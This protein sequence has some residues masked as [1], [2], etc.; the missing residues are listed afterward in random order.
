[1]AW[2][3]CLDFPVIHNATEPGIDNYEKI[4]R[5]YLITFLCVIGLLGNTMS[6][7]VLRRDPLRREALLMLQA[8]AVADGCY[9][10]VALLRYPFQF[11]LHSKE[12]NEM[13]LLVFP[14]VKTFQTVTIW[15]MLC[16]T[17]DRFVHVC[18]PLRARTWFTPS[19]RR[20]L[21]IAVYITGILYNIP[22]FFENCLLEIYNP[23]DNYT[24]TVNLLKSFANQDR[25]VYT[26]SYGMYII[27]LYIVP[28][29]ALSYM[30]VRLIQAIHHSRRF[31][32]ESSNQCE[33]EYSD[34]NATL[35][36]VI[37][38][39][40]FVVCQTPELLVRM[41]TLIQRLGLSNGVNF[42]QHIFLERFSVFSEFLMVL[43]SS[44]NFF[45]YVAFGRR[46]RFIMKETFRDLVT[47]NATMMTPESAPMHQLNH[48]QGLLKNKL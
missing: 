2:C 4:F 34:N 15:M 35:V 41:L 30:N 17:V 29:T 14:L 3:H 31:Q 7:V 21:T 10:I 9:I 1:M 45:I 11:I 44:V 18:W 26:Y 24:Y 23:H 13:Q 36:L 27:F 46:F 16:V 8:L 20:L 25:Y 32:R 37:I 19:R 39:L 42:F 43:N 6:I 22:R 12:Y 28:L 40:V 38:V 47:T 33:R 48:L 5:L